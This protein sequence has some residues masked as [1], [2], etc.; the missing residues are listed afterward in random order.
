EVLQN[1]ENGE[2]NKVEEYFNENKPYWYNML[3]RYVGKNG[4]LK[5]KFKDVK[6]EYAYNGEIV[7]SYEIQVF[8]GD[9]QN[10]YY[11]GVLVDKNGKLK[12]R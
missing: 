11:I 1:I 4:G 10:K 3:L 8:S 7:F 2:K 9:K 5:V 12:F 6:I